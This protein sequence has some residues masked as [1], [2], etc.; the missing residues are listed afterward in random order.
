M[1]ENAKRPSESIVTF[2]AAIWNIFVIGL[3]VDG[4]L[5]A[6]VNIAIGASAFLWSYLIDRQRRT[7]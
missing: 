7:P 5:A 3:S 6:S 4:D 1:M 2:L